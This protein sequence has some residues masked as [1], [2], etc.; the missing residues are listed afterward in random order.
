MADSDVQPAADAA[1]EWDFP[2]TNPNQ[3][4]SQRLVTMADLEAFAK[5]IAKPTI[6]PSKFTN[7]ADRQIASILDKLE[8]DPVE[9]FKEHT[10][11]MVKGVARA[12]IEA[13]REQFGRMQEA[14][15]LPAFR[16]LIVKKIVTNKDGTTLNEPAQEYLR[17]LLSTGYDMNGLRV[18][19][20]NQKTL[21]ALRNSAEN[22]HNKNKSVKPASSGGAAGNPSASSGK[23]GLTDE[24]EADAQEMFEAMKGVKGYTIEKARAAVAGIKSDPGFFDPTN[25]TA[26]QTG[27]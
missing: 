18:I 25:I 19:A 1:P 21:D 26:F 2:A 24:Q 9:G 22:V 11:F 14:Q 12:V 7:D 13:N 17:D 10:D 20:G 16:D 3:D 27:R 5:Q 8:K 6:D 15:E 4:P 23:G